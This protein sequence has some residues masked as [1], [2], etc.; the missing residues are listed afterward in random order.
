MVAFYLYSD[1]YTNKVYKFRQR[2]QKLGDPALVFVPPGKTSLRG[3]A[4]MLTLLRTKGD[5]TV[6]KQVFRTSQT[7]PEWR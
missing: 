2:S 1:Y 6:R 4:Y 5:Y 7:H 3:S